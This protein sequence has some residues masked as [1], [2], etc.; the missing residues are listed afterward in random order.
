MRSRCKT[1]C[2][3]PTRQRG[4]ALLLVLWT[5]AL[6]SVLAAEFAR[7]MREDAQS[8][9]NFKQ[10]TVAHYI[11]VAGVNEAIL[12]IQTYNGDIEVDEDRDGIFDDDED[13]P[14]SDEDE[15]EELS[16]GDEQG[17]NKRKDEDDGLET[18]RSLI[19]GRGD[20]VDAAFRGTSYQ[21]R[22]TDETGKISLN[23]ARLDEA[24][25][26]AILENLDYDTEDAEIIG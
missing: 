14:D 13:D 7:A 10:E 12:A 16:D 5:F 15:D 9:I 19:A 17:K 25:L 11:A 22:V 18:V 4:V 24:M 6:L 21:V 3:S 20:W 2:A 1:D 23:N 26:Q 8:T